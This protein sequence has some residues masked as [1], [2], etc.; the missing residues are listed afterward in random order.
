MVMQF[1]NELTR[2]TFAPV[3]EV[4]RAVVVTV[5]PEAASFADGDWRAVEQLA[6][7]A[8]AFRSPAT[9][10]QLQFFLRAIE[11]L[12]I[13]RFGRRFSKLASF[14]RRRVLEHLQNHPLERIRTGFWGLRT[15][16]FLGYYG[17]PEAARAIGYAPDARGWE[18]I[19]QP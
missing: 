11:W 9:R 13:L 10:R 5:L 2:S 6:E 7:A 3:R 8:L 1:E 14:D 16:A 18:A 15:L 12:T 4:Y 17:R 19:R